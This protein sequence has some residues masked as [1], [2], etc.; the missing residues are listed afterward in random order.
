MHGVDGELGL[1]SVSLVQP[2]RQ[3]CQHTLGVGIARQP[4]R[5]GGLGAQG[6]L[7]GSLYLLE[8]VL[9]FLCCLQHGQEQ[10]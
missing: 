6:L 1:R 10:V 5:G 3:Y 8:E 9:Q 4:A 2:I 7:P